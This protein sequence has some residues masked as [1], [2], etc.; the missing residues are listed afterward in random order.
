MNARKEQNKI[1]E[2]RKPVPYAREKRLEV[3]QYPNIACIRGEKDT[4]K[5]CQHKEKNNNSLWTLTGRN[6]ARLTWEC[7]KRSQQEF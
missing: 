3:S 7:G 5:E 2:D 4:K 6:N 1:G